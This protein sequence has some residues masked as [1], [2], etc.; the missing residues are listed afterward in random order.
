M[1][2]NKTGVDN[3]FL[4]IKISARIFLIPVSLVTPDKWEDELSDIVSR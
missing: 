1:S 3:L 4:F 2:F